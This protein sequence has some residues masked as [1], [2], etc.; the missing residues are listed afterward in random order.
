[1]QLPIYDC[2]LPNRNFVI[3]R[4]PFHVTSLFHNILG[5][6]IQYSTYSIEKILNAAKKSILGLTMPFI[7]HVKMREKKKKCSTL[8]FIICLNSAICNHL[9]VCT[10]ILITYKNLRLKRFKK[11]KNLEIIL[12][13]P[14]RKF[15]WVLS[16]IQKYVSKFRTENIF[17]FLEISLSRKLHKRY[18]RRND[19]KK[20]FFMAFRLLTKPGKKKIDKKSQFT[21]SYC[22]LT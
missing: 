1:M 18:N 5:F 6:P 20:Y 10:I 19:P 22:L 21:L 14:H 11:K 13:W 17:F 2:T 9:D 15:N 7:F 12:V 3:P 16:V 8:F 4:Y